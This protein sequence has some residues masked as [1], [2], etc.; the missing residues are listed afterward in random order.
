M[1]IGEFDLA[2]NDFTRAMDLIDQIDAKEKEDAFYDRI[3]VRALTKT[4]AVYA[5]KQEYQKA[6]DI[7]NNKLLVKHYAFPFIIPDSTWKSIEKD[8]ELIQSRMENELLKSEGDKYLSNK[9]YDLAFEI[10]NKILTTEPNNE[11]VLSN[12]SLIYLAQENYDETIKCCTRILKIFAAFKEKI[13]IRNMSN[14][15]EIKIL[16]R[17]AKCYE[18]KNEMELAEK[19]IEAIE[20]L[21]IKNDQI[22]KDIKSIKDKMKIRVVN[23]YKDS[24]NAHMKNSQFAEAL[25]F[26]DKAVALIKYSN[27]YNKIDLVKILLNRTG[28]LIK[29]TQYDK[30]F[31][32]FEKILMILS[33]QKAI[34]DIQSNIILKDE[35]LNLEF[36]TYV[37]RAFVYSISNQ[38]D[39]AIND[40]NNALKI[41]PNDMAVKVNLQKLKNS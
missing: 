26:Y 3:Y 8:R 32:E 28:C 37:K 25:S 29:L 7:I 13:R 30:T 6:L 10:Y 38:I 24:A 5:L 39:N 2:L 35:L 33:K 11:K 34:A 4:Y 15:F 17:R 16:L 1:C 21:E 14:T 19:D 36:L 22:L 31:D 40:Y 18:I 41:K 12:I 27:I 23:S 9:Q 20:R